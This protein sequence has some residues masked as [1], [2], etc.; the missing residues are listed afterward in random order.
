MAVKLLPEQLAKCSKPDQVAVCQSMNVDA[1]DC[2]T[3][4]SSQ[5]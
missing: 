3:L 5:S 4:C 1:V 2:K